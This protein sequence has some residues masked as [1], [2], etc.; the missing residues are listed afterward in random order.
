MRAEQILLGIISLSLLTSPYLAYADEVTVSGNGEGSTNNVT[1]SSDQSTQ[2]QQQNNAQVTDN[3]TLN[4]NT[5]SNQASENNGNATINTGDINTTSKLNNQNINQSSAATAC[6]LQDLSAKISGNGPDSNNS[7]NYSQD[8]NTDISINNNANISSSVKGYANT[9]ENKANENLGNVKITTGDI[10]A[11]DT[12]TNKRVNIY[13]VKGSAGLGGEVSLVIKD[14]AADSDNS[15]KFSNDSNLKIDVN[16]SANLVNDSH[17]DLNTG[18]NS[19]NKNNGDVE[20]TTGD[21][22]FSS[23]IQNSGI[24]IGLVDVECCQKE[25]P[26]GGGNPPDGNPPPPPPST[27]PGSNPTSNSSN[28]TSA[29]GPIQ[30]VLGNVLPVTGNYSMILFLIGNIAMLFLGGYLRLRSG[31][32]PNYLF[33]C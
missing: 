8:S 7:I 5:G 18:K 30:A 4:A 27:N 17:W 12:I 28:S 24:N 32:S 33:A 23:T 13:D 3:V 21:I 22:V 15:I 16:N 29:G 19:A 6:C 2:T 14:N 25:T 9:G 10:Y 11:T 20:I 1:I 31:R 26:S